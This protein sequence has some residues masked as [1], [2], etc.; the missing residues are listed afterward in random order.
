MRQAQAAP[1]PIATLHRVVQGLPYFVDWTLPQLKTI[2]PACATLRVAEPLLLQ[3]RNGLEPFAYF[4]LRGSVHLTDADGSRREIHAG[5]PDAGY[6]IAQARPGRFDLLAQAGAE[7]LRV[8]T[9]KLRG[10]QR[11]RAPL[12]FLHDA[13]DTDAPWR[14]WP[15]VRRLLQQVR[16]GTLSLPVLPGIALR[17]KNLLDREDCHLEN[18]VAI[19]SADPAITARLLKVANSAVFGGLG[20]CDS[21]KSALSRL[22]TVKTQ[23]IVLSLVA[24]DL[25]EARHPLL[26]NCM[27]QR[28]RH[29]VDMAALCAVLARLTPGLQ[30]EHAM[31]V[32]LLHEVGVLPMLRLAEDDPDVL[33]NQDQ[34]ND[35]LARLTPELSA[36]ILQQWQFDADIVCAARH[37]H[38]WFREHEGPADDTDTLILAHLHGLVKQRTALKLP[39]I[40]ETPAFEKLAMGQ[41]TPDLSLQVLVEARG[42]IDE[43]K[44]LLA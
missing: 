26:K 7:L 40:D 3:R 2:L 41:L 31:L 12:N 21:V 15:L 8:E 23:Q 10:Q 28:W 18:V 29:A 33:A 22:G 19:I 35:M 4:L 37:Q 24:R 16:E 39:R 17:T 9:S 32:G 14:E 30:S 20:R 11:Q 38:H 42:Q 5:E 13:L 6:P 36:L 34:F 1:V 27:L 43:L 25:F 44:A